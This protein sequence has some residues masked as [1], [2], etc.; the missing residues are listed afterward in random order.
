MPEFES[1]IRELVDGSALSISYEEFKLFV[2][3]Q[4]DPVL[5]V[6]P[7]SH[8]PRRLA[9]VTVAAALVLAPIGMIL[10]WSARTTT[11]AA[12]ATLDRVSSVAAAL[13]SAD[14]PAPGQYL[15]YSTTEGDVAATGPV[16]Q[17]MF[18]MQRVT[19]LETWVA[20]DGSGRQ[21]VS[22][23]PWQLLNESDRDAWEAAGS[24]QSSQS[25]SSDTTFPSASSSVQGGPI[26]VGSDGRA[27]LAY[28]VPS[29]IPTDPSAMGPYLTEHFKITG[30]PT[31]EFLVAGTLL[32]EGTSPAVRS[33]LFEFIKTIPGITLVEHAVDQAGDQGVGVAR[34]SGG[35]RTTL[36]FDAQTS[37]V[38]GTTT[39]TEAPT[40]QLGETIPA[41]TLISF[42]NFGPSAVVS[43]TA[44]LPVA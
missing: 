8:R 37:R 28:P 33:A 3:P 34:I 20:P 19:S 7:Q 21:I 22:Y 23:G 29:D 42:M 35:N 10:L 43:S 16:G 36:V 15:Y 12:A 5:R 17:R 14:P 39:V 2:R 26:Y 27:R 41:G 30:G 32:Q 18:P 9:M 11:S 40:T 38:L 25:P 1:Q 31:T 6:L 13:P 44:A 24:P 4:T